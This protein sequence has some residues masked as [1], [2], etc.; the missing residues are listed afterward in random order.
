MCGV[1]PFELIKH[2]PDQISEL[3]SEIFPLSFPP[4]QNILYFLDI[5]NIT[6]G[7]NLCLLLEISVM[8]GFS[9]CW[10][11][12][13]SDR[14]GR[15]WELEKCAMF[16]WRLWTEGLKEELSRESQHPVLYC[17]SPVII[18][19]I[20]EVV[21]WPLKPAVL[22]RYWRGDQ[23]AIVHNVLCYWAIC[24]LHQ[25]CISSRKLFLRLLLLP[26]YLTAR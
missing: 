21:F 10:S 20:I 9:P 11:P 22:E 17:T 5:E 7:A 6:V 12:F 18:E 24:F 14:D 23:E 3:L 4:A 25:C 13:G 1:K 15:E 8:F 16:C 26:F 19:V 2:S